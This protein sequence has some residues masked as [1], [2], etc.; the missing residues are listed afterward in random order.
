MMKKRK[1]YK[2][3]WLKRSTKQ[4]I[5]RVTLISL[6]V[7]TLYAVPF[8][9]TYSTEPEQVKAGNGRVITW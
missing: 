9:N 6:A 4:R 5:S 8:T 2:K 7:V 1:P 3:P